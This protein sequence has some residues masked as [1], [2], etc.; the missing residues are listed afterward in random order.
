MGSNLTADSKFQRTVS[1]ILPN[2]IHQCRKE[3]FSLKY[4]V[5]GIHS[6]LTKVE[7]G[8]T[9]DPRIKTLKKIA[10]GLNVNM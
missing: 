5:L 9:P 3:I 6:T 1:I 2:M 4:P 10:K 8:A 7:T